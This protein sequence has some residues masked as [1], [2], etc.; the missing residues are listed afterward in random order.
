M[1]IDWHDITTGYNNRTS[2]KFT[3]LEMFNHLYYNIGSIQKIA[4]YLGVS[5]MTLTKQMDKLHA[6]RT[7]RTS[8]GTVRQKMAE[9]PAAKMA[10]MTRADLAK[11]LNCHP[12]SI[13][14]MAKELDKPYKKGAYNHVKKVKKPVRKMEATHSAITA[15][16][17]RRA[18]A[19][20]TGITS[21]QS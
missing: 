20:A 8:W 6:A 1:T 3:T 11:F 14:R 17:R 13:W 7:R 12:A 21:G 19:S 9:I 15:S 5:Y 10:N 18:I 16:L 2:N 4:D